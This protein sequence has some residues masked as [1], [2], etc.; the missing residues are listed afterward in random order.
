MVKKKMFF[1]EE[2]FPRTVYECSISPIEKWFPTPKS[3]NPA[4]KSK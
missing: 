3:Q 2:I 1:L 4:T